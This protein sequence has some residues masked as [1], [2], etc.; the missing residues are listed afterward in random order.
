MTSRL[1]LSAEQYI[2][3]LAITAEAEMFLLTWKMRTTTQTRSSKL[4]SP[5][6]GTS[7][8]RIE[9]GEKVLVTYF[10]KWNFHIF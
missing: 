1:H 7:K 8:K 5:Y 9:Y 4:T 10:K 2:S 6:T 3:L